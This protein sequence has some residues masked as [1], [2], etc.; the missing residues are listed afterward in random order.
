MQQ[1]LSV[2]DS[3]Q[4]RKKRRRMVRTSSLGLFHQH[5]PDLRHP[6]EDE[7]AQQVWSADL[8]LAASPT[9]AASLYTLLDL[10]KVTNSAGVSR[11]EYQELYQDGK[12]SPWLSEADALDSFTPLQLDSFH[13]L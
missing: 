13:T 9:V 7:F 3:M 1:G 12:R 2:K 4:G 6:M 8:G 11:W 5:P 10:H